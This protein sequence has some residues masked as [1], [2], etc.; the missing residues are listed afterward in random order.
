VIVT[1][2]P[3]PS[4][5]RTLRIPPLV[6][7]GLVRAIAVTSEAGGKGINVARVLAMQGH[8]VIAVVPLSTASTAVFISLLG[9][10]TPIEAVAIRGEIR[11]NVTLVEADGTVT[12]VNEPGP[13]LDPGEVDALL[14]RSAAVASGAS[15]VVGSGSLPPGTPADFYPRLADALPAGVRMA[16]DADGEA[17]RACLGRRLALIKPNH[18][19]LET[20]V[21][22]PLPTLGDVVAAGREVVRRGVEAVLVSLGPDGA[23]LVDQAGESH[24]EARID[25]LANT[26]GAG[27]ALLAGFL[28][29]GGRRDGLATAV[30]WSVAACRSP[31]TQVRHVKP[32]DFDAVIVHD[33]AAATRQLAA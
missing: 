16:V 22:R 11:V 21:G 23:L 14:E 33:A 12:K 5:D 30:A 1:V 2:T 8:P 25:D 6:R 18:H 24:A 32:A 4:V 19:E 26:V 31:G 15:W 13:T 7:G 29:S 28:A 3:N 27:D 9:T 17:L 10:P 20:L